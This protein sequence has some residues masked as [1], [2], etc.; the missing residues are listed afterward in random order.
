MLQKE[1]MNTG[2]LAINVSAFR[3]E[4]PG[5]FDLG[6]SEQWQFPSFDQGLVVEYFR[7]KD[8][9]K[10]DLLPD[11]FNYKLYWKYDPAAITIHTHG[12]KLLGEERK[13]TLCFIV[14]LTDSWLEECSGEFPGSYLSLLKLAW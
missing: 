4:L 12:P 14:N 13:C 5:I 3:E 11:I 2:V 7:R 6:R 8:F 1:K 9:S 10:V